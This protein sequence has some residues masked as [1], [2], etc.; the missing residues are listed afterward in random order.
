[1]NISRAQFSLVPDGIET[2]LLRVDRFYQAVPRLQK[3]Y[4][5]TQHMENSLEEFRRSKYGTW[6]TCVPCLET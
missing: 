3:V 6:N 2:M 4:V 1:M 5:C